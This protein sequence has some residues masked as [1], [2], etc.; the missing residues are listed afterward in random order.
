MQKTNT[1]DLTHNLKAMQQ[2]KLIN[3]RFIGLLLIAFLLQHFSF[4][5]LQQT[6]G[7]LNTSSEITQSSFLEK[8]G[9]SRHD[10]ELDIFI[11]VES[12][13]EDEV[14]HQAL[15]FNGFTSENNSFKALHYSGFIHTL[16]LRL[17]TTNLHKVEPPLF[18]LYHSWKS[19]LA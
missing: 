14:H 18:L 8:S 3:F 4:A 16:Y 17:A 1:V 15:Y 2:K 9:A 6:F 12:E 10:N 7:F 13:D 5:S 19:H 11:E